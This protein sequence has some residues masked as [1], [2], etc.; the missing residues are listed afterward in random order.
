MTCRVMVLCFVF[1]LGHSS[2]LVLHFIHVMVIIAVTGASAESMPLHNPAR[3]GYPS[4]SLVASAHALLLQT[5]PVV[6]PLNPRAP[7]AVHNPW[8]EVQRNSVR[9]CCICLTSA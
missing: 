6:R 2:T 7:T 1:H 5:V 4:Q 3:A 8:T 9:M